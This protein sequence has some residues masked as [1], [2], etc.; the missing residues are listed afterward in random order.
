MSEGKCAIFRRYWFRVC[1]DDGLGAV[2]RDKPRYLRDECREK[3][4]QLRVLKYVAVDAG[5]VTVAEAGPKEGGGGLAV[6]DGVD[7]RVAYRFGGG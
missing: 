3:P 1:R 7:G 2:C 6:V 5:K 4:Q